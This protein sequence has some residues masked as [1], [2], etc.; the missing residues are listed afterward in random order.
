MRVSGVTPAKTLKP[1]IKCRVARVRGFFLRPPRRARPLHLRLRQ[2]RPR[3]EH[4]RRPHQL[5]RLLSPLRLP[6]QSPHAPR[7]PPP[8]FLPLRHPR[9]PCPRRL[10]AAVLLLSLRRLPSLGHPFPPFLALVRR[11][12]R[13]FRHPAV[14]LPLRTPPF[15][16]HLAA[17]RRCPPVRGPE[18]NR[19]P[20][21]RCR[22]V[23]AVGPLTLL[24]S[25]WGKL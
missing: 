11:Q 21:H 6:R 14:P 22:P 1:L 18:P 4:P 9:C 10:S 7:L 15:R 16:F 19:R 25:R 20:D 5:L 17:F 2:L 13:P 8:A 3:R 12:S 23:R 24:P